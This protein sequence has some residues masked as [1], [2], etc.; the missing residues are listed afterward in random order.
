MWTQTKFPSLGG[1]SAAVSK[2]VPRKGLLPNPR[3]HALSQ[4]MQKLPRCN[5]R[6]KVDE[7]ESMSDSAASAQSTEDL[8]KSD[9]SSSSP[10]GKMVFSGTTAGLFKLKYSRQGPSSEVG[11]KKEKIEALERKVK[12]FFVQVDD[13]MKDMEGIDLTMRGYS[14]LGQG[15]WE[16]VINQKDG[17]AQEADS[18]SSSSDEDYD[19]KSSCEDSSSE[20]EDE[21]DG[22]SSGSSDS[23]LASS[24]DC[25][26]EEDGEEEEQ[27]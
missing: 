23:S 20:G 2:A 8:Q 4:V 12:E 14:V 26:E 11:D 5:K 22:S 27:E 21:D 17:G 19:E 1:S 7:A 15:L 13:S 6:A 18:S 16:F 3:K 24:D 10:N 9:S 25:E